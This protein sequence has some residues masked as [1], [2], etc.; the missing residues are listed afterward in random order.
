MEPKAF[1]K[2]FSRMSEQLPI[3][4]IAKEVNATDSCLE[5]KDSLPIFDALDLLEKH[6]CLT[7]K[8]GLVVNRKQM[9]SK[10]VKTLFYALIIEIEYRLYRV[11]KKRT[12]SVKELQTKNFN[13]MIKQFIEDQEL[14]KMQNVYSKRQQIKEDL[15]AISSFRNIIMHSNRKMD[16]DTEFATIIKR[17][18]QALK[19]LDALE[20]LYNK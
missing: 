2:F 19:L 5:V 20:Q 3:T 10:P 17:K 9:M 4:L 15:K 12:Q 14:L 1:K 16:L 7:L 13:D 8:N 18:K 11:L 6:S